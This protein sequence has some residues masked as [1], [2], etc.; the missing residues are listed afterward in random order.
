MLITW[1]LL[2]GKHLAGILGPRRL[3][4]LVDRHRPGRIRDRF[5]FF[6]WWLDHPRSRGDT[7]VG[8]LPWL[9]WALAALVTLK[10]WL[11]AYCALANCVAAD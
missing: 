5:F 2:V 4:L 9:P 11:R 10:V 3:L 6:V 1:S 7:I 8:M